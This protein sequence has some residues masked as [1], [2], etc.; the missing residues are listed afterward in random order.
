MGNVLRALN[1]S[2]N[3]E[4][5]GGPA[6]VQVISTAVKNAQAVAEERLRQPSPAPVQPRSRPAAVERP[7]TPEFWSA[8]EPLFPT[9]PAGQISPMILTCH[10]PRCQASE[11]FRQLRTSLIQLANRGAVRCLITS[12]QP[13][14]GKSVTAANL[15]YSF[16]EL[17]GKR[18]L[19]IDADLRRGRMAEL[20]GLSGAAGLGELLAAQCPVREVCRPVRGTLDVIAAGRANLDAIGELLGSPP[21]QASM[22]ALIEQYD[23]VVLDSPP[24]LTLADTGMLGAWVDMALMVVRIHKTPR[25][26]TDKA[27]RALA[28]AGVSLAGLVALDEQAQDRKGYYE[29]CAYYG[30]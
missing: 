8:P 25:K 17:A 20:F 29:G 15:A 10:Q 23:Y 12:A 24:V 11:Q 3:T 1:K 4:E 9:A 5:T 30:G 16:S 21:A 14:E 18:T 19:L 26:L 28:N 7:A 27:A 13:R 2:G 6:V 22:R